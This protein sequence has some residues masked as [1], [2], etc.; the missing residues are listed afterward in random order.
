MGMLTALAVLGVV[1]AQAVPPTGA[2]KPARP[3]GGVTA[4]AYY[5]FM[6]GRHLESDGE[7]DRAIAA[8]REAARL[9][10]RAA[11]IRAELAGLFARQGRVDDASR[12]ARAALEI[13]SAN[14]EANRILGSILASLVEPGG[15]TGDRKLEEAITFLERG[16]SSDGTNVDPSLELLLSRLYLR[17]REYDKA[18]TLLQEL[19]EREL[20]PEAYLLLAEAWNGAGKPAEAAH[21]LEAG[22]DANPRLLVSLG[23]MYERQQRWADAASTY[24]RAAAATPHSAEV[25][26]RWAGSLLNVQDQ[27]ATARARELLEQLAAAQPGDDRTLYLLSQAQRRSRDLPAAE[28]S[29]RRVIALDPAG[30]WGP[31][32][33]AQ[34]QEDRHDYAGVVTTLSAALSGVD[35]SETPAPRQVLAMYTHLGFAQLQLGKFD[36]AASTFRRAKEASGGDSAYD[37]YLAQAQVS[38]RQFAEALEV[39]GPLRRSN[40]GDARLAQLEA[41]ALAGAGRRDEGIALLRDMVSAPQTTEASPY[42]SLA[43]LLLEDGRLDEANEVLD[44]AATRF[45]EDVSVSFQRGAL[46]ERS[47]QYGRAEEAFRAVLAREPT[48]A[49]A[50]NFLGYMLADRGER[51]E[52]AVSLIDRAL[53]L[54]PD[55]GSYLDSLGWAYFKL[56]RH[57]DARH[58]LSRAAE[59]LPSNSVVQDHLGDAL[60]AL[61][62]HADAIAAWQRALAGDRESIDVAAIE[63]KIVRAKEQASR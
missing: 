18:I 46:Y 56:R 60:A 8:Y 30:L 50:L 5:H 41:R 12:E 35:A 26:T 3:A 34:V 40:P 11:E 15:K 43:D 21:A 13:D 59:Q 57:E 45:P 49:Q 36:D 10:P 62:R 9:D 51:L 20:V 31:W 29:A 17:S 7:I 48:H 61:G 55:N 58:Y 6:L 25:K 39:L 23:E 32:A 44:A 37:T 33:L 16:R 53:A 52:E 19:L 63:A 24:E 22:A 38:G 28:A 27:S 4:Q 1:V 14:Q 54:D 47:H 2:H 42:L